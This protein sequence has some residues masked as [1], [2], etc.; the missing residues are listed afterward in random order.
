MVNIKLVKKMKKYII[1]AA[2]LALILSFILGLYLYKLNRENEKIAFDA[3]YGE[4]QVENILKEAE[5]LIQETSKDKNITTPNTKIIEKKYYKDCDHLVEEKNKI[6]PNLVNKDE[7]EIQTQYIGWEIQKF[8]QNEVVVYKE[9]ND[10]CDEHY[11]LKDVEGEIVVYRL[12][13]YN[14]PKEVMQETGIQTK[15]LSEIDVENLKE[16]IKV[17]GKEKLSLQLED[18]E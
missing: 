3:K 1:S 2:I 13:K 6:N 18:F 11:L 17:C 12:D 10:F 9:V 5:N 4:A 8:S 16:G 7:S 14:V 15:Y